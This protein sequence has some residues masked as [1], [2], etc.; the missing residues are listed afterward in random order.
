[1]GATVYTPLLTAL[2][3]GGDV[4]S[5][6]AGLRRAGVDDGAIKSAVV[7]AY[8]DEYIYGDE[9][10]RQRIEQQLL[11]L[12]DAYGEPY[13]TKTKDQDDFAD[14]VTDWELQGL[15]ESVY[16]DLNEALATENQAAAQE[17]INRYMEAG[18]SAS[19]IRAQIANQY[20]KEYLA[21]DDARRREIAQF[22]MRLHGTK[23][24]RFITADTLMG[25][26][27]DEAKAR[28][29]AGM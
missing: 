25:W 6:Q 9:S 26:I 29:A 17:Q 12:N 1:M 13:F 10:S 2:S 27:M 8:K 24:E 7:S 5:I 11:K 19:S 3:D 15:N 21:A 14:W 23:G 28:A 20:K 22:I 4:K 18:K 16:T